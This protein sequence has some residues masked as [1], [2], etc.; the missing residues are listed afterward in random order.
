MRFHP[1]DLEIALGA[2]KA[3]ADLVDQCVIDMEPNDI[4]NRLGMVKAL[5]LKGTGIRKRY[6][7]NRGAWKRSPRRGSQRN[8]KKKRKKEISKI[9]DG[10]SS[11]QRTLTAEEEVGRRGQRKRKG[12]KKGRNK[13]AKR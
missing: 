10:E 11:D 9:T 5:F 2:R 1:S 4:A 12:A 7:G 6:G 8:K 13:F 3:L